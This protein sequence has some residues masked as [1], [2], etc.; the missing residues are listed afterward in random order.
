MQYVRGYQ[1]EYLYDI[2]SAV[3]DAGNLS[4]RPELWLSKYRQL[5]EAAV[6]ASQGF[7]ASVTLLQMPTTSGGPK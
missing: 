4:G 3:P 1:F 7:Q 6:A 5:K 2:P